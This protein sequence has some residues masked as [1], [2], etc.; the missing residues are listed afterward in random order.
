MKQPKIIDELKDCNINWVD[1]PDNN[2]S[3]ECI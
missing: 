1:E 3:Q 2:T